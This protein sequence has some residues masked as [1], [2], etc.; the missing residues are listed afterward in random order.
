L[1][2][3][4]PFAPG[5]QG[6]DVDGMQRQLT[7]A[8]GRIKAASGSPIG[9]AAVEQDLKYAAQLLGTCMQQPTAVATALKK[10]RVALNTEKIQLK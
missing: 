6:V 9:I 3:S 7:A 5:L 4:E 10:A 8:L 2:V 1:L